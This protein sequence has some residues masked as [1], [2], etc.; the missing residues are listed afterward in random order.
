MNTVKTGFIADTPDERDFVF[1]AEQSLAGKYAGREVL[2]PNGDWSAYL[3]ITEWQAENYETQACVSYGTLNAIEILKKRISDNS[4]N[5]SDRYVAKLS[6]TNP[7]GG[8]N[9]RKVADTVRKLWACFEKEWPRPA[10]LEEFYADVPKNLITLATGRGAYYEFGYETVK[11][12]DMREALKYSPLGVSLPAWFEKDNLYY[13][14]DGQQD[15]HWCVCFAMQ[16]NGNLMI[17]D[18]YYPYIKEVQ[19]DCVPGTIYGYHL[20]KQVTSDSWF[21]TF[22]QWLSKSLGVW[23]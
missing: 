16:P 15:T 5:L 4:D 21:T 2:Q 8:N 18:S 19:A 23:K 11:P 9:P 22:L 3:P 6:D 12:Q 17:F 13:R 10:T 20:T 7:Y 14:P 1:G